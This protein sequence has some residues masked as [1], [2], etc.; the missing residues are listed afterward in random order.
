MYNDCLDSLKEQDWKRIR[1]AMEERMPEIKDWKEDV[2]RD[3]CSAIVRSGFK[4]E[5]LN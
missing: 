2:F 5:K 4:K 3:Y 1:F